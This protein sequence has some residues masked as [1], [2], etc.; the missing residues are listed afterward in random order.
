MP[1]TLVITI[2]RGFFDA[3]DLFEASRGEFWEVKRA[4]KRFF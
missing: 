3:N 1:S 4:S 2:L